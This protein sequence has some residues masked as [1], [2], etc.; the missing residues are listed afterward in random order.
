MRRHFVN[1]ENMGRLEDG[2][3]MLADRG[4]R[5]ASWMLVTGRPGEGKTTTLYNWGSANGAAFITLRRGL[6]P[7]RMLSMLAAKLGVARGQQLDM[8]TALGACLAENQTTVIL[9]E[10]QFGLADSAAC[11][12]TLR[13]ITDKSGTPVVLVTMESEVW[14][15]DRC[16]QIA[17]RLFC[18]VEFAPVSVGDVSKVCQ[19]LGEVEIAPDLVQRIQADAQ[20]R[21]RSVLNAISRIEMAAKGLSKTSMC[22]ADCKR[23]VLVEDYRAG[24]NAKPLRATPMGRAS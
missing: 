2:V 18:W 4:A 17:S 24:H 7:S 15:F 23:M 16:Q 10:A 9:D 13:G 11:L 1:I 14:R 8:D 5:E 12:E 3:Q 20:G 21:M 19:Q 22:A 6:S